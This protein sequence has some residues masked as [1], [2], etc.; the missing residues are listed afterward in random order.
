MEY[1]KVFRLDIATQL[2]KENYILIGT[3]PNRNNNDLS[4]FLFKQDA[5][6]ENRLKELINK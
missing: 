3:E 5:D 1:I 4:V 2:I 6:I